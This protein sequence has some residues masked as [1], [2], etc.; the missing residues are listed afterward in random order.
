MEK[1]LEKPVIPNP[2]IV[3]IGA[4][5]SIQALPNGDKNGNKLPAA[6]FSRFADDR[7]QALYF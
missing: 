1:S 4:G 6:S 7:L 3:I 2:H 5:A